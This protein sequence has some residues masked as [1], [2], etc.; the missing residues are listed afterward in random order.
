MDLATAILGMLANHT[1]HGPMS[2]EHEGETWDL[3]FST[4]S[5]LVTKT[6]PDT[7]DQV[8]VWFRL[9]LVPAP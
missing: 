8:E 9:E 4:T 1:R 5:V 6:D 3:A 7:G 2:F